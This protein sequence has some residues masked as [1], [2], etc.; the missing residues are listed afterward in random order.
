MRIATR[1]DV[2]AAYIDLSATLAATRD[3]VSAHLDRAVRRT[4]L[5]LGALMV[6]TG[7]AVVSLSRLYS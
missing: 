1:K 6:A 7:A 3:T 5:M 4:V 2:Y